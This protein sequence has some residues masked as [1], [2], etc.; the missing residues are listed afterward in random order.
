MKSVHVFAFA[1]NRRLLLNESDGNFTY[2]EW[3]EACEMAEEVCCRDEDGGGV[4]LE[5]EGMDVDGG[6]GDG[7]L[8]EWL[9]GVVRRKVEWEQRWKKGT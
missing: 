8:E 6:F 3:E 5:G 4:K 7:N 9:R 2:E 1:G